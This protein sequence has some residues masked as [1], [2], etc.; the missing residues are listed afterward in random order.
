[1]EQLIR[2]VLVV[3]DN[4]DGANSM[5]IVLRLLGNDVKTASDGIEAI[6]IA[7]SYSPAIILMDID[8]P[9]MNGLDATRR[10]REQPWGEAV[11]IIA[12]TGWG[13]ENDRQLSHAAGCDGHLVKPVHLPDLQKMLA[14]FSD[15]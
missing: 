13:Q 6:E 11:K 7:E 2:R 14:E 9:R 12:L 4:R 15:D 8:L 10:I 1:L 3:D 5:A